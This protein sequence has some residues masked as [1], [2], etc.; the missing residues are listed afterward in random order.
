[1]RAPRLILG[2]QIVDRGLRLVSRP[3]ALHQRLDKGLR[4]IAN[5]FDI[6]HGRSSKVRTEG[7]NRIGY[8]CKTADRRAASI[9]L[10]CRRLA[11][12]GVWRVASDRALRLLARQAVARLGALD[13]ARGPDGDLVEDDSRDGEA[14][15]AHRIGRRQHRGDHEGKH[16]RPFAL[17]GQRLRRQ[18][19]DARQKAGH[20][21][22]LEHQAEG[23]DQRHDQAEIFRNLRQQRNLHLVVGAD[24]LHGQEEPHHHRG[25]EEIDQRGAHQEQDGR[26]DQERQERA[27][28]VLVEAGRDELVDLRGDQREGDHHAAE[29]GKLHLGEEELLRRRIDQLDLVRVEAC[30]LR[31][32]FKGDDQQVEQALGKEEADEEGNEEAAQRPD[33]AAAQLDEMLDQRRRRFLD[34]FP[35]LV[36]YAH[37]AAPAVF[38]VSAVFLE[39][40]FLAAAG[41]ASALDA[42]F[43]PDAAALATAGAALAGAFAAD[44]FGAAVV[45]AAALVVWAFAVAAFFAGLVATGASE[46]GAVTEASVMAGKIGAAGAGSVAPTPGMS[47]APFLSG[48]AGCGMSAAGAAGSAAGF[49]FIIVSTPARTS[50][51]ACSNGLSC[52]RTSFIGLR[53]RRLSIELF[54]SS[55]SAS[56]SASLNCFW[57]SPAMARSF[58]AV[59]PKV[60]SMLGKSLGP[61]TTI[62]TTA[63]TSSSLQPTSNMAIYSDKSMPPAHAKRFWDNGMLNQQ[64]DQLL[65]TFSLPGETVSSARCS[66]VRLSSASSSAMPF[67]K[68]LMPL[69]MSPISSG[70]LPRP[71]TSSTMT[72]TIIQCQI[73]NE[74]IANLSRMFS[75]AMIYA[76][77]LGD[78]NTTATKLI[79]WLADV[80]QFRRERL[81][82][83]PRSLC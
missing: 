18:E 64:S 3:R 68:L 42:A 21:R 43:P 74:P 77:S 11:G 1:M 17:L 34:F 67:L 65:L 32:P 9:S 45:F 50:A 62:M 29:H 82:T 2:D 80:T 10:P 28:L 53:L 24:L 36:R 4:V 59:R 70:I 22:Q 40:G 25:E 81:A 37:L 57:K 79:K 13:H 33:Q 20:H 38:L 66:T 78:S 14:A 76:F 71:N 52:L 60:R 12:R 58:A 69:A 49:G 8:R 39:A 7:V 31:R 56:L 48:S 44:A 23:E 6:K 26:C 63:I 16:D 75:L 15:L 73:E 55:S 83:N 54:T 30:P 51:A 72:S 5:P 35:L 41:F 19:P 27:A 47:V 61:T 46:T